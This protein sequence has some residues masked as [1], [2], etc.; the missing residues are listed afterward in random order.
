MENQQMRRKEREVKDIAL[1]EE[2]ISR[3]DI[4]RVGFS[5]NGSPY[6]V[7]LNF[8]Y[9]KG[10]P[11]CLYFHCATKGRKIDIIKKN[12][13]VCFE[14]DTDHKLTTGDSACDY[15]FLYSSVMGTGEIFIVD[16]EDERQSGLNCLMKKY[17]GQEK[18]SYKTGTMKRT[19]ILRLDI[20]SITGKQILKQD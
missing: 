12:K 13:R 11:S 18:H 1:I 3:C 17:T 9:K 4:C 16:N 2:I 20:E 15:S 14:L 7:P 10:A 19:T 5:D 8:G 6:I